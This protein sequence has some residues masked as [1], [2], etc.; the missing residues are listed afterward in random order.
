MVATAIPCPLTE[1]VT[2]PTTA[3]TCSSSA[4][5]RFTSAAWPRDVSNTSTPASYS[6][7]LRTAPTVRRD[8]L[9]VTRASSGTTA[10]LYVRRN[11]ARWAMTASASASDTSLRST[12]IAFRNTAALLASVHRGS[13]SL[14][15]LASSARNR[16][17]D[18]ARATPSTG[19]WAL[20]IL[21][22]PALSPATRATT[23][24]HVA[25]PF[26]PMRIIDL[27]FR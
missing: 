16:G 8:A 6:T 13:A 24:L 3:P 17:P 18:T 15:R 4:V 27:P 14:E 10:P 9:K 12:E 1:S 20:V 21:V 11:P 2:R 25:R 5:P 19:S 26:T 23:A 22:P 7:A